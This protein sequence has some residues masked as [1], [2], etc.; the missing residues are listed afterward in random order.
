ML[1]PTSSYNVH[2]TK[3]HEEVKACHFFLKDWFE[4]KSEVM[5]QNGLWC[6]FPFRDSL[7]INMLHMSQLQ[8][9]QDCNSADTTE[10]EE[11]QEIPSPLKRRNKSFVA[12]DHEDP[13]AEPESSED[14]EEDADD[15]RLYAWAKEKKTKKKSQFIAE[16]YSTDDEIDRV[17]KVKIKRLPKI[18][19]RKSESEDSRSSKVRNHTSDRSEPVEKRSKPKKRKSTESDDETERSRKGKSDSRKEER[20]RQRSSDT[21]DMNNRGRS[22]SESDQAKRKSKK[23]KKTP[24]VIILSK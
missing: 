14:T 12:N 7:A 4:D 20:S 19:Q 8:K 11:E 2:N 24:K 1:S 18:T 5:T 6:H 22:S 16:C 23:L 3:W 17:P 13:H 15:P 21:D 10:L 9:S